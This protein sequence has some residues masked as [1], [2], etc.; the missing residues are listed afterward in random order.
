MRTLKE[1]EERLILLRVVDKC[2]QKKS[3]T[4]N[5]VPSPWIPH[6]VKEEGIEISGPKIKHKSK[7]QAISVE[8][9]KFEPIDL[10]SGPDELSRELR[11]KIA[12]GVEKRRNDMKIKEE[13]DK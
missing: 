3:L 1:P 6:H 10:T 5:F 12:T 2:H 8:G 4:P 13:Q 11:M 9:T 7:D